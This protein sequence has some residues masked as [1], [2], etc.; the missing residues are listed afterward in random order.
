MYGN[1]RRRV[2]R[3]PDPGDPLRCYIGGMR[4]RF[5]ILTALL[6]LLA[7]TA[8]FAESVAAALCAPD[9][10]VH[11]TGAVRSDTSERDAAPRAHADHDAH[12]P[13][14][15]APPDERHDAGCPFGMAGGTTCSAATLPAQV[16]AAG[17]VPSVFDA[18]YSTQP[19]ELDRL[20]PR[21]LY[22]P[23]RA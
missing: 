21:T 23:P 16:P 2:R 7:F 11:G 15:E 5:R 12:G 8:Y 10:A 22:R 20:I 3:H 19:S 6:A 14:S 9:A 18:A 1:P 13:A 4:R 17:A